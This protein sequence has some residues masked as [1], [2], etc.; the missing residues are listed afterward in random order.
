MGA[1]R[2]SFLKQENLA[3]I[4]ST[5]LSLFFL[6]SS[7]CA[8]TWVCSASLSYFPIF[9]V[10]GS[11][12]TSMPRVMSYSARNSL[13][14]SWYS[15]R[16]WDINE[17]ICTFVELVKY[18]LSA[19]CEDLFGAIAF[20]SKL[21][22]VLSL[23]SRHKVYAVVIVKGLLSDQNIPIGEKWLHTISFSYLVRQPFKI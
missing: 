21:N 14:G 17:T 1:P 11:F 5:I 23:L 20:E 16:K 6:I 13:G 7:F 19:I 2:K 9:C 10:F 12:D 3:Q 18:I 15:N 22:K 4:S 8:L